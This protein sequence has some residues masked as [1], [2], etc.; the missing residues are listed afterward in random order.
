MSNVIQ[1]PVIAGVEITTDEH[2][3]F[4]L[5]ALHKASRLGAHKAP[6]QWLRTKT[7]K[8]LASKLLNNNQTVDSQ[9]E[10]VRVINGGLEQGTYAVQ[11]LAVAYASWISPEFHLQVIDVFLDYKS[12]KLSRTKQP[13][14]ALEIFEMAAK[15]EKER[16]RLETENKKLLP[17]ANALDRLETSEGDMCITNAS[18]HLKMRRTDLIDWLNTHGWIY[19]RLGNKEWLGYSDKVETGYLTHK[20]VPIQSKDGPSYIKEQVMIKPKGLTRLAELLA[21]D[22]AA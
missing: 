22:E 5:N 6:N 14:T 10:P 11:Q 17:K 20:P 18:K 19:R 21:K 15:S 12:G 13:M 4:N 1:L 2:G 9:P 7:A 16:L 3:R 8:T